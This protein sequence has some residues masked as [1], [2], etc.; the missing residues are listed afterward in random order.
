MRRPARDQATSGRPKIRRVSYLDADEKGC[1]APPSPSL[2]APYDPD[3]LAACY[4]DEVRAPAR[5]L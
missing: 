1:G 2:Y 4:E 3:F 5:G